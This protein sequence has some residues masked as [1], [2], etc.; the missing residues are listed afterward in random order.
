MS[1]AEHKGV[2]PGIDH[3]VDLPQAHSLSAAMDGEAS[4]EGIELGSYEIR[5]RW[6]VYHLIGDA[7]RDPTAMLP[8]SGEF[9]SRMSA[10]LA[11]ES[12]HGVQMP[13]PTQVPGR[14]PVAGWRQA[15]LAWPGLAVAGAVASVVW[16]A[17]P[18]F[19][20]EYQSQQAVSVAQTEPAN[21]ATRV[22]EQTRPESDYVSAHRQL[23][24]PI[25]VRQV[26][27]TP[28]VD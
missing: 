16:V 25:A 7:L 15:F 21:P 5:H 11:R 3:E 8:V 6:A 17:Q 13:S 2:S 10:A 23:A 26:A 27:F 20:L 14:R 19:D 4:F 12:A 28:G 9:S 1:F 24:G 22:A 18:L